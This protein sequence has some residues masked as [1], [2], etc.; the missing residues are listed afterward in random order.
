[1]VKHSGFWTQ[2]LICFLK[3]I[4]CILYLH[5]A[6]ATKAISSSQLSVICTHFVIAKHGTKLTILLP[7]RRMKHKNQKACFKRGEAH[8][9]QVGHKI[10]FYELLSSLQGT[11]GSLCETTFQSNL[12]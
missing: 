7:V 10:K 6:Y 3:L 12:S 2:K 4:L 1:M 9:L 8:S 5:D 11:E